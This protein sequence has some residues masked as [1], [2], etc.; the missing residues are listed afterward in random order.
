MDFKRGAG[1]TITVGGAGGEADY[2][3]NSPGLKV[4]WVNNDTL[5]IGNSYTPN[6]LFSQD[7]IFLACRAPAVPE[8]GD[9]ASDSVILT[10]PVSGLSFEVRE[11]RQYR[12]VAWE[13]GIAWGYKA[14]KDAHIATILG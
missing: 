9:A 7:A 1:G 12:Q 6:L 3:L 11:Y 4:A 2:V 14:I 10:D 5:A 8:E 13:I